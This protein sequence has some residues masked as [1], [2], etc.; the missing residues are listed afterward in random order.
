MLSFKT[1]LQLMLSFFLVLGFV[2]RHANAQ[3]AQKE[4]ITKIARVM[5]DT[6]TRQLS[7]SEKQ[8][9]PVQSANETAVAQLLQLA[10]QK[11]Q[12]TTLQG[13]ALV[14][15]VMGIIKQRDE[16]VQK[17][18]TPDQMK[19]YEE[20]KTERMADLQTQM[21]RT[22][23]DLTEEQVPKV[24]KINYKYAK[25]MKANMQKVKESERRRQKAQAAK[26]AKADSAEKDKELKAVLNPEQYKVYEK[27]KQEMQ[28]AIRQKMQEKK[29]N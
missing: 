4:Q 1:S 10:Q 26:S 15:Q 23:L 17:L 20:L 21:M 8:A 2:T 14:K 12:D 7:L 11:T 18:L 24:Y 29:G 3:D 6:M 13:S 9:A 5:T 19:R 25:I 22:Q 16:A 28:A 27:N